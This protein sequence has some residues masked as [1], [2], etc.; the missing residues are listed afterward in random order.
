MTV[1]EILSNN[2]T[3]STL[4]PGTDEVLLK[5]LRNIRKAN[6]RKSRAQPSVDE[7]ENTEKDNR[8]VPVVKQAKSVEQILAEVDADSD[9]E[10]DLEDDDDTRKKSSRKKLVA[11]RRKGK[12]STWIQEDG[13]AVDLMDPGS[14]R[15]ISASKPLLLLGQS[16]SKGSV[17]PFKTMPDGRLLI[18]EDKDDDSSGGDDSDSEVE[19][20]DSV[21]MIS[22]KMKNLGHAGPVLGKR[23]MDSSSSSAA[24]SRTSLYEAG[25]SG[26][27]RP[28]SGN[29]GPP[30]KR[31]WNESL[32]TQSAGGQMG[33]EFKA[34]KGKGD[35]K[36]K[37]AKFDP[38]AYVPL[39]K[40]ALNRRK[41]SK[42]SGQFKGLVKGARKGATDGIRKRKK[43][44]AKR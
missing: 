32:R 29:M 27:H 3:I 13:D 41:Q 1:A 39:K 38:F 25:G 8:I 43:Q 19:F 9:D 26:I 35:V 7:D 36:K 6:S 34:K 4:V 28:L 12:K 31:R 23:K 40:E 10:D 24:G 21:S 16:K 22:D 33:A 37:G 15:N 11:G 5:C 2:G 20:R 44:K 42:F 18:T 14:V 30:K 17:N